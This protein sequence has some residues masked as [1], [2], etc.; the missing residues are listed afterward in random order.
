[1]DR[2]EMVCRVTAPAGGLR[3]RTAVVALAAVGVA[4]ASTTADRAESASRPA[5]S[6]CSAATGRAPKLTH[7]K[8][9]LTKVPFAPFG[10][11]ALPDGR[12]DFVAET[13]R[14]SVAVFSN[15]ASGLKLVRQV[16]LPGLST[17]F[18]ALGAHLTHD[19][20]YLLVADERT[21]A[22]VVSV[23]KAQ[24]G[25]KGAVLGT[26]NATGVGGGAIEV[27]TSLD[28]RFAFVSLEG[29]DAIAVFNLRRALTKGFGHADF[30]GFVPVGIAP[31][32]MAVSP[33]G[34]WLYAT[35]ENAAHPHGD[36]GTLSVI[37]VKTAESRPAKSVVATVNAG[38]EPVRVITSAS[39][40][41]V[42]V[43]ARASDALLGFSATRLI[44]APARALVAFIRVGTAPVGLALVNK[45]STIVVADSDR[46]GVKGA[47]SSLAIV[48]VKKALAGRK[49]LVGYL[50]A[51]G[52]PREM[53]VLPGKQ[54][55]LVG[56]FASDQIES[57]DTAK[58]P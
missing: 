28:G 24:R 48:N 5:R 34:R 1:M 20:R 21:G 33:D 10:V 58:L 46:F 47:T 15:K 42:W 26:L 51:G 2:Q 11:S 49:A 23:S 50:R 13:R 22:D 37:N 45:G 3:R 29:R 30:V 54:T 36:I 17:F 56:N 7:V 38:C 39:G 52:F 9:V 53:A 32:G 19:S 6:T 27:T 31:V 41:V 57:V 43:T 44:T 16:R 25:A 4:F 8:T 12:W 18:G 40:S 55:L 14:A 35:S